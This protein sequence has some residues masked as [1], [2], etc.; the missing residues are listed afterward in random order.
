MPKLIYSKCE[1][2]LLLLVINRKSEIS[3]E[4]VDLCPEQEYLQICTKSMHKGLTFRPHKHN[5]LERKTEYT[6][7]AWIILEGSVSATFWDIDDTEVFDTILNSGD[8][9]V[10]FRAGHSF[11]VLE[12]GTILYEVKTGPYYGVERDKTFI[13]ETDGI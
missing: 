2:D 11:E 5:K 3:K 9:A 13:G 10:V 7:E 1:E 4:R 6:Q 12:E 8:C